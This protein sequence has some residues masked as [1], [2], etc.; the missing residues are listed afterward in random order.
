MYDEDFVHVGIGESGRMHHVVFEGVEG[1]FL[2]FSP[3]EGVGFA[4]ESGHGSGFLGVVGDEL[5]VKACESKET[6]YVLGGCRSEPIM[7][8]LQFVWH[9]TN[10]MFADYIATELDFG[11]GKTALGSLGIELFFV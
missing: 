3:F 2:G 5:L 6:S 7:Y 4:K 1:V 11:L 9:G 10:A 8:E